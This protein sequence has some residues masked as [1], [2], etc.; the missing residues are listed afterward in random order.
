MVGTMQWQFLVR[1]VA[2]LIAVGLRIVPTW[3]WSRVGRVVELRGEIGALIGAL[4][5][6]QLSIL[7]DTLQLL[8]WST[9]YVVLFFPLVSRL[10]PRSQ[11]QTLSRQGLAHWFN[12]AVV[13][14]I[15]TL[16]LLISAFLH[17][18]VDVDLEFYFSE[19]NGLPV[20]I[21]I[22]LGG[23]IYGAGLLPFT[24]AYPLSQLEDGFFELPRPD[25][26]T[27][28][29]LERLS[30][31]GLEADEFDDEHPVLFWLG[32]GVLHSIP[33]WCF[34]LV[35]LGL[36]AIAPVGE[37]VLAAGL[38]VV[39]LLPEVGSS[40]ITVFDIEDRV[41]RMLRLTTTGFRGMLWTTTHVASALILLYTF[42][43][44]VPGL[45]IFFDISDPVVRWNYLGLLVI[46]AGFGYTTARY[47]LRLA[48]RLPYLVSE[49][50]AE[51]SLFGS[52]DYK[53]PDTGPPDRYHLHPIGSAVALV[54][55]TVAVAAPTS[56]LGVVFPV[57]WPLL[58]YG[59]YRL[60]NRSMSTRVTRDKH[61]IYTTFLT[62]FIMLLLLHSSFPSM[63]TTA[64]N[65]G[66]AMV[67]PD[68]SMLAVLKATPYLRTVLLTLL[69]LTPLFYLPSLLEAVVSVDPSH[70]S[71]QAILSKSDRHT[72]R[73]FLMGLTTW[74]ILLTV[75]FFPGYLWTDGLLPYMVVGIGLFSVGHW[76]LGPEGL[77]A[78]DNPTSTVSIGAFGAGLVY[79]AIGAFIFI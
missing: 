13:A 36:D 74:I 38:L 2:G 24:L 61:A 22:P 68:S 49:V 12:A 54:L 23:A 79:L 70:H 58:C 65:L 50:E 30:P 77:E 31:G 4:A 69:T 39:I 15:V 51:G 20:S 59:C 55:S 67:F 35:F 46:L 8:V 7:G 63:F 9:L 34:A 78:L 19:V 45:Q 71:T 57:L 3:V 60:A 44:I 56:L 42:A 11:R 62:L 28:A 32:H 33:V 26:P 64:G 18:L 16:T 37:L 29:F 76:W 52:R 1:V 41:A 17:I 5:A 47:W 14:N 73:S 43:R 21:L 40:R 25:G 27:F 10:Y 53:L 75:A 72:I 48:D 6:G 66:S